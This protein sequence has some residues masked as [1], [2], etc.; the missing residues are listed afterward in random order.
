MDDGLFVISGHLQK[1]IS[2]SE[3]EASIWE[4]IEKFQT[5]QW[6]KMS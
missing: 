5:N 4:E 3:A 1:G 6:K 2:F